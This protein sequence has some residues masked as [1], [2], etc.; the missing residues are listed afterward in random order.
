MKTMHKLF[1]WIITGCL[2][3]LLCGPAVTEASAANKKTAAPQKEQQTRG[4]VVS[5]DEKTLVLRVGKGAEVKF[6]ITIE[7]K[8]GDKGGKSYGDFK[9]GNHVQVTYVKG[10]GGRTLKQIVHVVKHIN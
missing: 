6:D 9:A 2:L 5:C 8:F 10:H 3:A 4:T 7:T 1:S